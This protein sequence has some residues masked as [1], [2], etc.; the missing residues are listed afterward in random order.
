MVFLVVLKYFLINFLKYYFKAKKKRNI[1]SQIKSEA[2]YNKRIC[3]ELVIDIN[4]TKRICDKT[5]MENSDFKGFIRD[6]SLDPFGF[7][8]L[9]LIQV[10]YFIKFNLI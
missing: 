1:L 5:C 6:I 8:L 3:N 10:F 2:K 9:S 7:L 4:A